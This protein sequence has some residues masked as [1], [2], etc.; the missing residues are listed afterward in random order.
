MTITNLALEVGRKRWEAYYRL[1]EHLGKG[2]GLA[3]KSKVK[4]KTC[5]NLR[6]HLIRLGC[7]IE[8]DSLDSGKGD[9]S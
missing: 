8:T 3:L 2:M 1:E 4:N 7:S 5:N 9:P 6:R